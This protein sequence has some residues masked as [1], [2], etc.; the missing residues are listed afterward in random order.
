MCILLYYWANKMMMM[1]ML[2]FCSVEVR[3]ESRDLLKFWEIS[4]NVS[5]T[6]QDRHVVT[7]ED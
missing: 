7:M 2:K 1:M 4:A 3:S 6:V 5:E